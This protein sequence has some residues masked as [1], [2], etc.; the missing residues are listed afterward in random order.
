MPSSAEA[1]SI[2]S[3]L[4]MPQGPGRV[5]A[6]SFNGRTSGSDPEYG[7]SNLPEA[8]IVDPTGEDGSSSRLISGRDRSSPRTWF[9]PTPL[10]QRG[11]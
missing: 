7:S 1:R 5:I 4:D 6:L 11:Q 8:A 9:D 3:R 10:D 2:L